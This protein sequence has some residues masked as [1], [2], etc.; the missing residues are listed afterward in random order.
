MERISSINREQILDIE[1]NLLSAMK[2]S[3]VDALDK[4]LHD[5]LLFIT[6]DGQTIT[7]EMDLASHRAGTM[8]IEEILPTIEQINIIDDTAVVTLVYKTKGKMMGTVIEGN[9]RYI[10]FWKMFDGA[11]KVIGGSCSQ[12]PSSVNK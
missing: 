4:M 9:F 5:D 3:D 10:R 2:V 7:K 12:I 8:I 1:N 11:L 6:P